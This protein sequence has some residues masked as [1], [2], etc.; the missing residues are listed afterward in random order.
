VSV[1]TRAKRWPVWTCPLYLSEKFFV[2]IQLM[3]FKNDIGR[4]FV[5]EPND[6]TGDHISTEGQ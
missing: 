3:R 2:I 4:I 1:K 5:I 6:G